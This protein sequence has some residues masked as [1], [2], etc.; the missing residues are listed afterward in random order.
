MALRRGVV[1]PAAWR[2][3]MRWLIRWEFAR[4]DCDD[5]KS[6]STRAVLIRHGEQ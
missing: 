3:A 5:S 1:G 2:L 4:D 6:V